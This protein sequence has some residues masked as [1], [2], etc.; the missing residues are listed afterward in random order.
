M[1]EEPVLLYTPPAER[2]EKGWRRQSTALSKPLEG[3]AMEATSELYT[4]IL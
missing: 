2:R 1:T 4:L 3:F